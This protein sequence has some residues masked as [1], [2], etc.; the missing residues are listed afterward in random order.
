MVNGVNMDISHLWQAI[1]AGGDL[2][3]AI[4]AWFLWRLD[5]RVLVVETRCRLQHPNEVQ[6]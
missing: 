3:T 2:A 6:E 4:I 5:R 1:Q